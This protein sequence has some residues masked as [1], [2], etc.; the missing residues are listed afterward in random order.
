MSS[1][2]PRIL[3]NMLTSSPP[4]IHHSQGVFII[5]QQSQPYSPH[6]LPDGEIHQNHTVLISQYLLGLIEPEFL[7]T[8]YNCSVI[9]QDPL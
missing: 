2:L 8:P 1:L 5:S 9:S 4:S 3:H 7:V 6:H